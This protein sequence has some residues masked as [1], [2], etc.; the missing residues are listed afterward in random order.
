MSSQAS[1]H[2]IR[3]T[4]LANNHKLYK[5]I[6]THADRVAQELKNAGLSK[7]ALHSMEARYLPHIIHPDEH[8]EGAVFG[9]QDVGFAMLVAT[10]WR[11][12][13]LDR[14]PLFFNEDEINYRYVSGV[15]FNHSPIG[16][17]VVL[18]TRIKDFRLLSINQKSVLKF[19]QHIEAK[20]ME[21]SR[22]EG[23]QQ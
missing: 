12:I 13:F 18:H 4:L 6:V 19:V 9:Y 14:K 10:N 11:V 22:M 3:R 16:T 5:L 21:S 23:Q 20:T 17:T 1:P 15:V 7:Y 2:Y 8:I